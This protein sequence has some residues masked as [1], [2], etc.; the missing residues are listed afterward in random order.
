MCV[1]KNKSYPK[2]KLIGTN[3]DHLIRDRCEPYYI[4]P[5]HISYSIGF[6]K[7]AFHMIPV[8]WKRKLLMLG[9]SDASELVLFSLLLGFV[10]KK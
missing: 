10:G 3:R 5:V 7:I 4:I 6:L 9:I 1:L 8:K 2:A